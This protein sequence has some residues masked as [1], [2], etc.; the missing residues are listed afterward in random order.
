ML[1]VRRRILFTLL[2]AAL[3]FCVVSFFLVDKTLI[4]YLDQF[5]HGLWRDFWKTLTR[6]GQS[7]WY[8][9]TG[10]ALYAWFRKRNRQLSQAGLFLFST[11]AVSGLLADILK[12]LLGR[13]R[14]K[15]FLQQGI[16]GFDFF[17]GHFDH[18]WTSFPSGHSATALSIAMTL[19]LLLPR[20]RLV[21]MAGAVLVISSR[22]ILCQHYLSDVIA[23]SILG[24][25][26]AVLL[27]QRYF[28][29]APDEN[30][31]I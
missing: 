20:F 24:F 29:T 15:L 17:H 31:I 26:T 3:P 1:T 13:A 30:R 6:A 8:L 14:P 5:N 27:Y 21:Y 28:R 2:S 11:V 18:A 7:E 10:L 16:Y 12:F 19:S 23:G 9:V 22:V 4:L 25:I